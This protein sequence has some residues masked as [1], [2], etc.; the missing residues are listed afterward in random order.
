MQ[1][2]KAYYDR[3]MQKFLSLEIEYLQ[4]RKPELAQAQ[5]NQQIK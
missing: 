1:E 5:P 2:Y 3:K 4:L